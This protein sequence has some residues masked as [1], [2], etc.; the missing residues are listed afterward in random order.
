MGFFEDLQKILVDFETS[1]M[2]E[3][4]EEIAEEF[5]IMEEK[6]S[7]E[8]VVPYMNVQNIG[9]N[10]V[11]MDGNPITA[12]TKESYD[13]I[14]NDGF[15][16]Y[17]EADDRYNKYIKIKT[18]IRM[19][20]KMPN[21]VIKG[22]LDY[23]KNFTIHLNHYMYSNG[24]ERD[25]DNGWKFT[26]F[27][28]VFIGDLTN[29][30]TKNIHVYGAIEDGFISYILHFKGCDML[31]ISEIGFLNYKVGGY[32][33]PK[34]QSEFIEL[35]N[36]KDLK[37]E[38]HYLEFNDNA[39]TVTDLGIIPIKGATAVIS[40]LGQS[41]CS[42]DCETYCHFRTSESDDFDMIDLSDSSIN[43]PWK[44]LWE[45]HFDTLGCSEKQIRTDII[46][47]GDKIYWQENTNNGEH[48]GN[49][50]ISRIVKLNKGDKIQFSTGSY[51]SYGGNY[52]QAWVKSL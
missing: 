16:Q 29:V 3:V 8:Y 51:Q 28:P 7:S 48:Y 10:L 36:N 46:K 17:H 14:W 38:G 44:G 20:N 4:K 12:S 27:K 2:A 34:D 47:N 45:I 42:M 35:I 50:S 26:D 5:A 13:I 23:M 41:S 21:I 52:C 24:G 19:G 1:I 11:D 9:G 49:S 18:K 31:R 25:E 43:I 22:N 33:L 37:E 15:Y 40:D 39:I 32:N 6:P 30:N